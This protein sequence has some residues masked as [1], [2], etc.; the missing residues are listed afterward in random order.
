MAKNKTVSMRL[1]EKENE[2][3]KQRASAEGISLSR[4]MVHCATAERGLTAH[5]KQHLYGKVDGQRAYH[6]IVGFDPAYCFTAQERMALS[7]AIFTATDCCS[8]AVLFFVII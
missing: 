6:I 3:I 4:Y 1:T 5:D 7:Y 8:T 2:L